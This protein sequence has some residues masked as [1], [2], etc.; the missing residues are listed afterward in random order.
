MTSHEKTE[1]VHQLW[2]LVRSNYNRRIFL[3]MLQFMMQA[4]QE[5]GTDLVDDEED[6]E[7]TDE[8][9]KA[10]PTNHWYLINTKKLGPEL[11]NL[12][13]YFLNL[14]S[15]LAC[16]MVLVFPEI[17]D[18]VKTW[19]LIID[20]IFVID[21]ILTFFKKTAHAITLNEIGYSY[22]RGYFV[23]DVLMTVPT[24]VTLQ[25]FSY[26]PFKLLR[27]FHVDRILK[28]LNFFLDKI[29]NF[30]G[31]NK[32]KVQDNIF[33]VSLFLFSIFASHILCC[34][35]IYLGRIDKEN[36]QRHNPNA[37]HISWVYHADNG[38]DDEDF[39]Q[40]YVN[41]FFWIVET[42]TTVGYGDYSGSN[43]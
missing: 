11:W 22:L 14:Y 43:N 40:I 28:I 41:A 2:D 4:K 30:Y 6:F 9:E 42:I 33:L 32:A 7:Y 3:N 39:Y 36:P 26:Y 19:E 21:I 23:L 16:P 29:L 8:E 18:R 35:W 12:F 1:R 38:F 20:C 13:I 24:L 34:A 27:F 25:N 5:K 37:S 15:M 10:D 31:L 17:Y